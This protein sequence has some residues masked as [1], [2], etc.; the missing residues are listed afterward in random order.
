MELLRSNFVEFTE[1]SH[2]FCGNK[3]KKIRAYCH[4]DEYKGV[5]DI[6]YRNDGDGTF[7]D[8]T[9]KAGVYNS[10]GKGL[11]VICLDYDND[12][13]QDIFVANDSIRN[14]LYR[15][16]GNGT[17]TDVTF[18]SGTGYN[19]DGKTEAGMGTDFGDY[20]NDGYFDLFVTN[21]ADETN[22]L[23][24]NHGGTHFTDITFLTGL[25]EE[26]EFYVGWGTSFVDHDNDGDQDLFIVNGHVIDNIEMLRDIH[27]F[28]QRDWLFENDGDGSFNEIS[29]EM[30]EYFSIR[31]PGRGAAFGDIDNDGD[32]DLL[33]TNNNDEAVLLQNDGG[34]QNNWL[35]VKTI[36][37]KSNRDGIGARIIV[38]SEDLTQ[39]DEVKSGS[40]Y[41]CQSDLRVHFGLGKR[42][43]VDRLEIRWPSG[44]VESYKNRKPNQLLILTEGKGIEEQKFPL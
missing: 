2:K 28:P 38:V 7:T 25:G 10:E 35:L 42:G 43:R 21:L 12:G 1:K 15:N 16:N 5:S 29:M 32:M 44:L 26:D 6:L 27:T 17:F 31:K 20:D 24:H 39:M 41:L 22:T 3:A 13:D 9:K 18:E 37:T 23:Y 19:Q 30:G 11:G 4:P 33:V 8:V 34:N 36:G 40:S 14:I